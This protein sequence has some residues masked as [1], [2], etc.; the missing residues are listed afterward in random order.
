MNR[1]IIVIGASWG[2]VTALKR[3]VKDLPAALDATVFVVQHVAPHSPGLLA[4]ILTRVGHLP[5]SYA[6]NKEPLKRGHIYVAPADHHLILVAPDRMRVTRGPKENR[7]RPSI[8][9]LFRSAALAFGRR[10]I[11]VILTGLLD[12]GTSGLRAIKECGGIAIV[13][14]PSDAEAPSMPLSALSNVDVDY[15]LP[16]SGIPPMLAQLTEETLAITEDGERPQMSKEL[17]IEVNIAREEKARDAG[18]TELGEPS[19]F[20]CPECHGTLL[21]LRDEHP[22]RYRCHTGHGYTA[23]ILLAELSE[24]IESTVWTSIR[25]IEESVMLMRHIAEH[26]TATKNKGL[27]E[28][29]RERADDAQRRADLVRQ[30]VVAQ[31][32]LSEAKVERADR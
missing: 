4:Q 23:D 27:A 3:L 30:A 22:L 29:F 28:Q 25:S 2:G 5:V 9:P 20:T 31:E 15:C 24:G 6:K 7:S 19:I 12:D 21:Q 8:D 14:S 10:V 16:L 32:Q 1:D 11:G 17:E 13:Q 18:V 26:L